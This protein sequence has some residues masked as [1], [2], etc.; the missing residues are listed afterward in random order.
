MNQPHAGYAIGNYTAQQDRFG[1]IYIRKGDA[2]L[3][4]CQIVHRGGYH[5]CLRFK[6]AEYTARKAA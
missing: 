4:G 5:A 6:T 1:V 3:P 2:P